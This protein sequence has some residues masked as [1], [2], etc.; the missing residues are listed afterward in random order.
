MSNTSPLFSEHIQFA[1]PFNNISQDLLLPHELFSSIYSEYRHAW[2]KSILPNTSELRHFW[3]EVDGHPQ[4]LGHELRQRPNYQTWAIPISFHGDGV[5]ITGVGKIWAKM[6]TLFSWSSM[7]FFGNTKGVQFIVWA[8]FDR[9]CRSGECD[10]TLHT[11]F[12]I[13]R[14]SFY[15]L[16]MGVWPDRPWNSSTRQLT[17][18]E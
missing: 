10:G 4:M 14:W 16:W 9:L 17:S 18:C 2:Q 15:W 11:F 8:V 13:L 1:S 12:S 6:R 3:R 7:V 5:P